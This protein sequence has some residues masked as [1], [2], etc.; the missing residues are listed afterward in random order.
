MVDDR[1]RKHDIGKF[2]IGYIYYNGGTEMQPLL[3][4]RANRH[5]RIRF[6][7]YGNRVQI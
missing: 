2:W 1:T 6:F 7:V 3:S 5:S 4:S